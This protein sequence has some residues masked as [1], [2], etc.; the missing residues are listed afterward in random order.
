MKTQ[1]LSETISKSHLT[2]VELLITDAETASRFLDLADNTNSA[3]LK[4]RRIGEAH[5]AYRTILSFLQRLNPTAH[6]RETLSK[7]MKTLKAR[8][9]AAGVPIQ[10]EISN[11]DLR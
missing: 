1:P 5:R 2:C 8:L 7:E 4:S 3:E 11:L 9:G 10:K 6:Q